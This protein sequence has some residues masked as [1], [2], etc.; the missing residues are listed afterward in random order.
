M[1]KSCFESI[2]C[3]FTTVSFLEGWLVT[4]VCLRLISRNFQNVQNCWY[5]QS[6]VVWKL[7]RQIVHLVSSDNNFLS[8]HLRW[9]KTIPKKVEV[10]K[11]FVNSYS[12][13]HKPYHYHLRDIMQWGFTSGV[14]QS[15]AKSWQLYTYRNYNSVG[16]GTKLLKRKKCFNCYI[17]LCQ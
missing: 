3:T 4:K 8:F 9:K 17:D 5:C 14:P 12:Q 10:S 15:T 2:L 6:K 16:S 13:Y 7:M 1:F 11:Y